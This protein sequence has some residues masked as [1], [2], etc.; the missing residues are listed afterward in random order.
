[1]TDAQIILYMFA[2]KGY[3]DV[4]NAVVNSKN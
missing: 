3:N 2:S 1:L 4:I